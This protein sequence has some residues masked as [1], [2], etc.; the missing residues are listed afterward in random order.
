M[1]LLSFDAVTPDISLAITCDGKVVVS[2]TWTAGRNHSTELPSGIADA[3]SVSRL[4]VKDLDVVAVGVGP[5]S[6][7]GIR[8]GIAMAKGMA[9]AGSCTLVGVSSL[10]VVAFE[11][12]DYPGPI[13][14]LADLGQDR[15]GLGIFRGP[16]IS[17]A[18]LSADRA[19]SIDDVKAEIPDGALLAGWGAHLVTS[20]IN[21]PKSGEDWHVQR[22][23]FP[24]QSSG[25]LSQNREP[26]FQ[27]PAPPA[28]LLAQLAVR[29]LEAGGSD[30]LESVHPNYLRLSA[31]EER[32][33]VT[34]GAR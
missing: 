33:R 15:L 6:Y 10:E 3:L 23:T 26:G 31:P 16:A 9:M 12:A 25:N 4:H 11:F 22:S 30:Q 27:S 29:Y 19:L 17:W 32:G 34:G 7:T 18:R 13:C 2:R 5:G 20:K 28:E 1:K 24:V 14:A 21:E 8:L